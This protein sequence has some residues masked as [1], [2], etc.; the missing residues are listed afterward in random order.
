MKR[1]LSRGRSPGLVLRCGTARYARTPSAPDQP[2]R[3]ED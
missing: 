2:G 1:T 3:G